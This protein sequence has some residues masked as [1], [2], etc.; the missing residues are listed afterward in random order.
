M[1]TDPQVV[2]RLNTALADRY[3]IESDIGSGG[4]ATVYLAQ[5]LKHDRRVAVKVLKPELA[6][7]L[8]ADRFL[9]EIKVTANLQHPHILPLHDSGEADGFL[10]YVMPFVEGESLR[11]RLD[12]EKQLSVDEAVEVARSVA[13]ALDYAHR[14][15]VIHR[16][17]KPANILLHDGQP[18]VADFG[19]ALAVRAAG[20]ERLTETG[21][22]LGTPQYMSP[23]QAS[24]DREVDGRSDLYS[25]GAVLYEMLTG[26]AP[27]SGP[28]VQAI[29][30]KLLTD[31][32]RPV[33]ELRE[34]VPAHVAATVHKALAKLPADRFGGASDLIRAV[35]DSAFLGEAASMPE[36]LRETS[37]PWNP[38]SK[39]LAVLA[40][41]FM[42]TTVWAM[43]RSRSV[44]VLPTYDVGLPDAAPMSLDLYWTTLTVSPEGDFVVYRAAT[45]TTLWYRS[46]IDTEVYRIAGTEGALSAAVSPD[47]TVIAFAT[48][49]AVKVVPVSGGVTET[50]VE[51]LGPS[52]PQWISDSR[53]FFSD[54][55]DTRLRWA[56]VETG[57]NQTRDFQCSNPDW[58][59]EAQVLC[60]GGGFQQAHVLDVSDGTTHYVRLR[61]ASGS[62]GFLRGTGFKL[63]DGG[64]LTYMSIDGNLRAVPFDLEA[65]EA[66]RPVTLVTGVRRQPFS[67]AGQYSVGADGTLVYA[68]GVN[69]DMG[70]L[71]VWDEE[72][73][74]VPL[75]PEPGMFLRW[76]LSPRGDK[77]A[78]VVEAP[79]GQELRV[80]D[81]AGGPRQPLWASGEFVNEPCWMPDGESLVFGTTDW[82]NRT[83]TLLRSRPRSTF[84]PDTLFQGSGTFGYGIRSCTDPGQVIG[85]SYGTTNHIVAIDLLGASPRMDTIVANGY[86]GALSPDGERLAYAPDGF[87]GIAVA[88]YPEMN[89]APLV[90]SQRAEPSWIS[91]TELAYWRQGGDFFRLFLDP[92]TNERQ[93]LEVLWHSDP[94]FSD[95]PGSSYEITPTGGLTYIRAT[96]QKPAPYLR[97]IP[98]WFDQMK[99]AVNEANR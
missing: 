24:G 39:S 51:A 6:A 68:E 97:V 47:G 18:M 74:V 11:A 87:N 99:R 13:S 76:S 53:V 42:V 80:Y 4:M 83:W 77:L 20:G 44:A 63:R 71:V 27:H 93:G 32:P 38:V 28:T 94:R 5:D 91:S 25:L 72:R 58:I 54:E 46:L 56:D 60:G 34:T 45:D 15:G 64:Y 12:R 7:V 79:G 43:A 2:E 75:L 90:A 52:N 67:G 31:K 9:S 37:S 49:T 98:N 48:L 61:G 73:G 84:P 86:F 21:L 50:V 36:D 33:T 85:Y 23:E 17:I 55:D 81:L 19:I 57:E 10:Y 35:S 62:E 65:F 22:S 95:T 69:G 40:V 26:E 1:A 96:E 66:G 89:R 8:G 78:A 82:V 14:H 59:S 41:L 3:R 92:A 29:I 70:E 30:A 88:T 16:D